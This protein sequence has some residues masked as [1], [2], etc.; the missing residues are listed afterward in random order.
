MF[1]FSASVKALIMA[2]AL[3]KALKDGLQTSLLVS[4]SGPLTQSGKR[5]VALRRSKKHRIP[6]MKDIMKIG[7][8]D[9]FEEFYATRGKLIKWTFRDISGLYS[10][11]HYYPELAQHQK[12]SQ[13]TLWG[14][15]AHNGEAAVP[16][17]SGICR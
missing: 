17:K 1:S 3:S 12:S 16:M 4:I 6:R 7:V 10:L 5:A 13:K 15:Q 2:V 8:L 9:R 11:L 14:S